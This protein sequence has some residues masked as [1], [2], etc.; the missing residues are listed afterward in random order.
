MDHTW[1]NHPYLDV[2][3]NEAMM[4][5]FAANAAAI[6]RPL[7]D[8]R[9]AGAPKVLG[10]T[11]MGNVSY[12]CP[13]IHPMLQVAPRGVAIHTPEF[14]GH[15]VS[16]AGD[17]AVV[18]GAVAMAHTTLDLWCTDLLADAKRAFSRS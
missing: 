11:D 14:A 9:L 17:R 12:L 3:D 7:A 4:A 8:P 5:A 1:D 13:S 16:P 6:G 18:D 15:A 2:R 10:S